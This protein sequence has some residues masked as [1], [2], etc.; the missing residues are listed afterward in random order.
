MDLWKE[1]LRKAYEEAT[2]SPDPSTQNGALIVDVVRSEIGCGWHK[3]MASDHTRFPHGVL[4]TPEHWKDRGIKYRRSHHAE[5]SV[6]GTARRLHG[7][8]HLNGF[9][10]VCPWAACTV[11]AQEI[12]EEGIT[13]LVTHKQAHERGKEVER[14]A[15]LSGKTD[16]MVWSPEITEAFTMLR[17]ARV[18][19]IEY[20]G[21]VDGPPVLHGGEFWLP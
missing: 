16:R 7:L 17:E 15:L 3:I 13:L 18:E 8:P 10:M 6:L 5:R 12:I 19:I 21:K 20:D 4:S 14:L 1:L 11:C 9:V 2:K